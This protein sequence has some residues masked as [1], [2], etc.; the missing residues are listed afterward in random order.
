MVTEQDCNYLRNAVI[1]YLQSQATL[2]NCNEVDKQFFRA[3]FIHRMD[4]LI[5]A[6]KHA[7]VF[8]IDF[9]GLVFRVTENDGIES[10]PIDLWL[11]EKPDI[12][13]E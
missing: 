11:E 8:A 4:D 13:S 5:E 1:G 10:F 12:S 3:R 9:N 2:A 6:M 7:K